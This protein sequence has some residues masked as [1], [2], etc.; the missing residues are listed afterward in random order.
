MKKRKSSSKPAK[1]TKL[2]KVQA[3]YSAKP[4]RAFQKQL[5]KLK[6]PK[7]LK[8]VEGHEHAKAGAEMQGTEDLQKLRALNAQDK[9][10]DKHDA[11]NAAKPETFEDLLRKQGKSRREERQHPTRTQTQKRHLLEFYLQKSGVDWSE[12]G[13][14]N[15]VNVVCIT[16]ASILSLYW[17]VMLI[18]Q[19]LNFLGLLLYVFLSWVVGFG[20]LWLVLW[21]TLYWYLDFRLYQR[22]KEIETILPDF[23]QLVSS[24]V[25]AGMPIDKA[26]WFA[27]RPKFGVLAK[28]METVAKAT[29]TGEDL[30]V[31]LVEFADKY[32]SPLLTRTVNLINEGLDA[33]GEM[34]DLLNK[35]AVNFEEIQIMK[36]EMGSNVMTYVIFISFA[37]IMAAPFLFAL[38]TELLII[39]QGLTSNLD[40]S[41][42]TTSFFTIS[43]DSVS[44]SDFRI[45]AY[46]MLFLSSLMS[47]M[48]ISTISKGNIKEGL[49]YIPIYVAVTI[50]LYLLGSWLLHSIFGA[51]FSNL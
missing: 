24:N 51:V 22:R 11:K 33:G 27:I 40:L 23:L 38:S 36:K 43:S 42:G 47:S 49:K 8:Q 41:G 30:K 17:V 39:I 3:R 2:A 15:K 34:A 6:Q 21:G 50:T 48:L 29:M 46:T 25:S 26:L 45:F 18:M 44:L 32:D 19:K 7:Q 35:I 16:V 13:V 9:H 10:D 37:S 4:G 31:A 28:E 20:L 14:R 12:A 5:K 1:Q